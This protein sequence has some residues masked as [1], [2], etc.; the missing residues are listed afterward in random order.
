MASREGKAKK[1]QISG[2]ARAEMEAHAVIDEDLAFRH[3]TGLCPVCKERQAIN[4]TCMEGDCTE[5]W[6][7]A[8]YSFTRLKVLLK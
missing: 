6:L 8:R 3:R 5:Q 2:R 4:V 1:T 7:R